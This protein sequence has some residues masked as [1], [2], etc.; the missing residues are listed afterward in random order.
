MKVTWKLEVTEIGVRNIKKYRLNSPTD[1]SH[2]I[3]NYCQHFGVSSVFA[4]L[5]F[6]LWLWCLCEFLCTS[7]HGHMCRGWVFG[8]REKEG[9]REGE[10]NSR[11]ITSHTASRPSPSKFCFTE[12]AV[13]T[14]PSHRDK[15][16][17]LSEH[18]IE[19]AALK[20]NYQILKCEPYHLPT[21]PP[22]IR[23]TDLWRV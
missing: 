9:G 11:G 12:H 22:S 14:F 7:S 20:E 16:H 10:R 5:F 21:Q 19:V 15:A 8:R 13:F 4:L 2:N 18:Q 3:Y 17:F 23:T 1:P 6:S